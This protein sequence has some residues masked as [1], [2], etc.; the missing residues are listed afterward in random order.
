MSEVS[1]AISDQALDDYDRLREDCGRIQMAGLG[2]IELTGEDRKGWLQGQATNNVRRLEAGNS[3]SF[4]FTAAT[5]HL[6]A[7]V[8]AWA[9]DDRIL[10]TT[11]P[12]TADATLDRIETMVIMED[13]V[14]RSVGEAF[15]LY[16]VQ[17]PAASRRLSEVVALPSLDAGKGELDG[18]E[19]FVL[20]SNRT[21]LGGWDVWVPAEA[22]NARRILESGF[23]SIGAEA[24]NVARLEA[25]VP[26]FGADMNVKTLPP[27]LGPAFEARHISYNKGCYVGQE[28]LMRIHSRGHVNRQWV[29]L[30][31]EGP[32]AVGST[33]HHP[34]RKEAGLVTSA[35]FSPDYGHIGAAMLRAEIAF[36]GEP[37]RVMTERGEVE[38]EVRPMPILRLD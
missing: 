11:A 7:V 30:L 10:L 37:V 20:R 17:G 23:P 22:E 26:L 19:V 36:E 1:N 24:Y 32:L 6:V 25:G 16:S 31:A 14:G 3:V 29:G 4:C 27:E 33:V 12:E 13:V 38:A 8:D 18:T 9:L 28:V 2:F 15:A 35:A 5:G 34:S 21:G